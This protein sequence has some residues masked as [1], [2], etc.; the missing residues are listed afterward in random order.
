MIRSF[1]NEFG[2]VGKVDCLHVGAQCT[3]PHCACTLSNSWP[4][5]PQSMVHLF[6]ATQEKKSKP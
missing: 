1:R 4:P 2:E 5:P 3:F 6:D